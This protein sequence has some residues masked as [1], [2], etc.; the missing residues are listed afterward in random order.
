MFL[1]F[2]L[3]FQIWPWKWEMFEIWVGPSRHTQS[4]GKKEGL[5]KVK[6]FHVN[7][8]AFSVKVDAVF[9]PFWS[10]FY[11]N[12][13][14]NFRGCYRVPVGFFRHK[15]L[16]MNISVYTSVS[17]HKQRCPRKYEEIRANLPIINL[18]ELN[19]LVSYIV[20]LLFSIS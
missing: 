16:T 9:F 13:E 20:V 8:D 6:K 18:T 7:F 4:L 19:I 10:L 1:F 15:I 17:Y 2:F 5:Q 11:L 3:A 14:F 12:W